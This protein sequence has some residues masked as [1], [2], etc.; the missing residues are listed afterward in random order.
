MQHQVISVPHVAGV[1]DEDKGMHKGVLALAVLS[2]PTPCMQHLVIQ[3]KVLCVPVPHVAGVV[4]EDEGLLALAV[5][6]ARVLG[7][8]PRELAEEAL[9]A[10]LRKLPCTG[11]SGEC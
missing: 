5:L 3:L 1:M 10:P 7:H 8:L 11:D 2:W 4:D 9:R 6:D